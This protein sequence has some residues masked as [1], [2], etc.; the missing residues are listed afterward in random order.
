MFRRIDGANAHRVVELVRHDIVDD[1]FEVALLNFGLT[2]PL[3]PKL[4]ITR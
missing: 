2:V 1:G 3:A 4:S